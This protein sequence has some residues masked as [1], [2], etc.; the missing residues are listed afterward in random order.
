MPPA[1]ISLT[2]SRHSS[3]SFIAYGRSS[4]LHPTS[5]QSSCM[6]VRVGRSAFARLC[7]GVHRRTSLMNP[8]LLLQQCPACLVCLTLIVFVIGGRTAT[9]LWGVAS[10]TCSILVAAFLCS[11]VAL[12]IQPVWSDTFLALP[13][14]LRQ[15][16]TPTAPL[17]WGNTSLWVS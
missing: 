11:Y 8:S 9:A 15:K 1:R 16:N 13:S 2:L 17:Q 12:F 3:L 5:S 7:E 6:Y 14:Q 10:R 4:G